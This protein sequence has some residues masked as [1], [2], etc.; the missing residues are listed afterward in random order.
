VNKRPPSPELDWQQLAIFE[1]LADEEHGGHYRETSTRADVR[2]LCR[3]IRALCVERDRR[4]D[5]LEQLEREVAECRRSSHNTAH[6]TSAL[7]RS[8]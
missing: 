4:L 5:R 7:D 1:L 3:T 2:L 6:G 8:L